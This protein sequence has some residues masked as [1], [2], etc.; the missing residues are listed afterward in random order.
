V[1]ERR[2]AGQFDLDFSSATQD[3]SPSGLAHSWSCKGPG[4]VG[5]YCDP[6]ADSLLF[7]AIGS[8][9]AD[10][11]LWHDWLERVEANAPAVFLYSQIYVAGVH[12]RFHEV[13]IRPVSP[14]GSLWRWPVPRT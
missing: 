7:R 14:W 13:T 5:R 11:R 10:R 8:P 6:S 2:A 4:N 9:V 12:R 1:T 3:P